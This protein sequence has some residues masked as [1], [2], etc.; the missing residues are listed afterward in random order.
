MA[1][2]AGSRAVRAEVLGETLA[3]DITFVAR[4]GMLADPATA[5]PRP[6]YIKPPDV[7]LPQP[8]PVA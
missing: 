2:V 3:P 5:L 4:L 8:R 7:K 1:A 6:L